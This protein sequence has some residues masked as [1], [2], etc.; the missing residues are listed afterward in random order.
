MVVRDGDTETP[1]VG[2]VARICG[3]G[4]H[5][6]LRRRSGKPGRRDESETARPERRD[7]HRSHRGKGFRKRSRKR[8]NVPPE[9]L[10]FRR[11]PDKKR[12]GGVRAVKVSS[13]RRAGLVATALSLDR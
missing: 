7:Q 12:P 5:L 3:I 1:G 4:G 6:R 9:I 11:R 10:R 13:E 8:E 2:G